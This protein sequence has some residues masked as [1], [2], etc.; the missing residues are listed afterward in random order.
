MNIVT[1]L[2]V[3]LEHYSSHLAHVTDASSDTSVPFSVDRIVNVRPLIAGHKFD[4][5]FIFLDAIKP[6]S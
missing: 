1:L 4:S 6:F 2:M 5:F 3:T